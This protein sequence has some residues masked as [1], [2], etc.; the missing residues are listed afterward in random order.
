M[1]G[2][3]N[4]ATA[5]ATSVEKH[6]GKIA[7]HWGDGE[8]TYATLFAQSRAVAAELT[9]KFGVKPGDRIALWVKNC[10]E[11]V[12]WSCP[13]TTSSSPPRWATS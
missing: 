13:S 8:F 6:P 2:T 4:L 11:F 5:F 3:M 7:L 10:P 1:S 9:G 12:A